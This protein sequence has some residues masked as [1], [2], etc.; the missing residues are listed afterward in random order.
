MPEESSPRLLIVDDDERFRT[1]LAKAFTER[2]YEVSLAED[3]ESALKIATQ[4]SPE[5][6]IVDL[7]MPRSWG[8]HVVQDL[9]R[10]DPNTDIIV[11]SAYGSIATALE[12]VRLGA[13]DFLQ[14]PAT[15]DEIIAAFN[16]KHIGDQPIVEPPKEVPT[17]ARTEWEHINRVLAEC[18]GSIRKASRLLGIHRR[19]LQRKLAKDPGT[20]SET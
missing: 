11:L 16:K 15:A 14:K 1:R 12:A 13:I 10:L 9:V 2:G 4:E 17:L 19:T 7:R 18:D 5:L 8:L 3:G 20:N 6:A